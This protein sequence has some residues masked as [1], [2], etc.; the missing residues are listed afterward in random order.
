[1]AEGVEQGPPKEEAPTAMRPW[2]PWEKRPTETR[3][4][5]AKEEE[6]R[7]NLF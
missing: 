6:V 5:A 3:K 7:D 2:M 4:E 1:M